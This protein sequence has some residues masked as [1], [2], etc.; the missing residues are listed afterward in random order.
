MA[1]EEIEEVG[2]SKPGR[3]GMGTALAKIRA[4]GAADEGAMVGLGLTNRV[5]NR[6]AMALMAS[7]LDKVAMGGRLEGGAITGVGKATMGDGEGA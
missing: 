2:G 1:G 3:G 5:T 4:E 7:S 6:V